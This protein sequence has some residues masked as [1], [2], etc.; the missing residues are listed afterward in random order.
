[1]IRQTEMIGQTKNI[2]CVHIFYH[3][4]Y[5]CTHALLDISSYPK[6]NGDAIACQYVLEKMIQ[7]DNYDLSLKIIAAYISY[8]LIGTHQLSPLLILELSPWI[9]SFILECFNRTYIYDNVPYDLRG[10]YSRC[11][12]IFYKG[13]A[14]I[15]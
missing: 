13:L 2:E 9:A 15:A 12:S 10:S 1:M 6:S 14:R 5:E 8:D 11:A 7:S 4:K 3:D